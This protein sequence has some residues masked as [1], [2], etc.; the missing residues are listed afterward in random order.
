MALLGLLRDNRVIETL[1][2]SQVE[3]ELNSKRNECEVLWLS[4]GIRRNKHS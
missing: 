2:V 1:C 3:T 4:V